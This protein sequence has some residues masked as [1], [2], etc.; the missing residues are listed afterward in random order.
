MVEDDGNR[1]FEKFADHI[2]VKIKQQRKT[3]GMYEGEN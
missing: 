3:R 1:N 2:L